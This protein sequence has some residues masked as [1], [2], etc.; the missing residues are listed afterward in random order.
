MSSSSFRRSATA[1]GVIA[2]ARRIV[3]LSIFAIVGGL[4][5]PL[6]STAFAQPESPEL[7]AA[8]D[9]LASNDVDVRAAAARVLKAQGPL[10]VA[11]A[12][13]LMAMLRDEA[14]T[15]DGDRISQLYGEALGAMGKEIVPALIERLGA[16]HI[17]E[18]A[19]VH[20]ALHA[21]GPDAAAAVE[22]ILERMPNQQGDALWA[23]CYVLEG[24]GPAAAPAVERLTSLL[25]DPNFQIQVIAAR[26]L[27]AIGP[28]AVSAVPK[29][30]ERLN[31]AN[32][33]VQGHALL[34]LG[35]IGPVP[36]H[37]LPAI[38]GERMIKGQFVVKERAIEALGR[39]GP[40]AAGQVELIDRLLAQ[41]DYNAKTPLWVTRWRVTGE[42]GPTVEGLAVLA[43]PIETELDAVH[44]VAQ[45]G[46]A[47][48]GA[49]DWLLPKLE[50]ID[51]DVVYETANALAAIGKKSPEVLDALRKAAKNDD[52]FAADGV[53]AALRRLGVTVDGN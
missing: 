10:A 18:A 16:V 14:I 9:D 11:A 26:A 45:L 27:A 38:I 15:S 5:S 48:E 1:A 20:E 23:S 33:S 17:L 39:L 30:L 32:Y 34:A 12:P 47:A 51:G 36:D 31:D 37:D 49:I 6:L 35:S 13:K 41:E 46:P 8:I 4:A 21:I 52:E 43:G 40:A 25:D 50:S 24:I 7:L 22:P 28:E 44:A 53:R 19:G 2:I 29:L 42:A 3:V